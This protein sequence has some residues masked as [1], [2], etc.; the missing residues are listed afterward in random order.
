MNE[1]E[2]RQDPELQEFDL[3]EILKEFAPEEEQPEELLPEPEAEPEPEEQLGGDTV[4]IQLPQH[5][6]FTDPTAET[7]RLDRIDTI[8]EPAAP[9]EPEQQPREEPFSE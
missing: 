2:N 8:E 5:R 1:N 4:R 6:T 7:V 9:P 3:D